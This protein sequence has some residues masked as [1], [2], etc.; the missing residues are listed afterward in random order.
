MV[1]RV[2]LSLVFLWSFLA[3]PNQALV[4]SGDR[5]D[6]GG[7]GREA[8]ARL[9]GESM[10]CCEGLFLTSF[11][12]EENDCRVFIGKPICLRPWRLS[13]AGSPPSD[14]RIL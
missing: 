1:W 2:P 12:E 13:A 14:S 7:R 5:H 4:N 8:L 11:T 9:F 10:P 6:L 3:E